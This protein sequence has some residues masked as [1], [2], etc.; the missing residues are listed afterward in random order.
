MEICLPALP[1]YLFRT[2]PVLTYNCVLCITQEYSLIESFFAQI[3]GFQGKAHARLPLLSLGLFI[4][5]STLCLI[6][7]L[8]N[9][10]AIMLKQSQTLS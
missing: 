5:L 8:Y 4:P 2:P 7:L 6:L 9:K 10:H 3:L 1:Y